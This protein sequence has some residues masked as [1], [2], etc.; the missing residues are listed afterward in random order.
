MSTRAIRGG[1][2]ASRSCPGLSSRP[3]LGR[4]SFPNAFITNAESLVNPTS[5]AWGRRLYTMHTGP[6]RTP[7]ADMSAAGYY[8]RDS[9]RGWTCSQLNVASRGSLKVNAWHGYG[10]KRCLSQSNRSLQEKKESNSKDQI[11]S[12]PTQSEP[13]STTKPR[14]IRN[15][16]PKVI[17]V[18]TAHENIYTVPNIL[19]FSRLIAA[20]FVG[21]AIVHDAPAWALGLFAYAGISDLLDGWIARR[22]KLQTVVGSIVD[23]MADKILMTILTVCLAYKGALPV[24]LAFI[25]LGRDVGLAISAIYYRWISLPPPKTFTRYWD[26]SLPSAEVKPTTISKYNTF[27]QLGLMGTTMLTPFITADVSLAM[28]AFQYLVATTTVWSGLS[29]VFSKDAVRILSQNKD[30]P[31]GQ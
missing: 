30:K 24:W 18:L 26:F 11:P 23:P 4:N 5:C 29:Y 19:T 25:I 13:L 6:L 27:L 17:P 15:V 14:G 10:F 22:W 8:P 16:I 1:A 12:Q 21:Y 9:V 3:S 20:P 2:H 28:S 31:K 7:N